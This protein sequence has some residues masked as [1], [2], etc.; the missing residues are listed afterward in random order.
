MTNEKTFTFDAERI[1]NGFLVFHA[2]KKVFKERS[3]QVNEYI[4]SEI[5]SGMIAHVIENYPKG[6]AQRLV[7]TVA[8]TG[9]V[10]E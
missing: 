9:K 5:K 1:A 10:M 6:T 3:N 7:V 8:V 2:G 4:E